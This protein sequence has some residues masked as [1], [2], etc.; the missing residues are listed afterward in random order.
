MLSVAGNV[1]TVTIECTGGIV[2][3]RQ[4]R[5]CDGTGTAGPSTFAPTS[6]EGSSGIAPLASGSPSVTVTAPPTGTVKVIKTVT[7][8][9]PKIASNFTLNATVTGGTATPPSVTGSPTGAD[10]VVTAGKAYS[11]SEAPDPDYTPSYSAGCGR[12]GRRAAHTVTAR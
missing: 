11:I 10:I 4:L 3:R 5:E 9:G 7:G 8:G 12:H 1:I 6:Q 2:D